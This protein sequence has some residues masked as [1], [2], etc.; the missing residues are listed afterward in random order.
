MIYN[1][2][3]KLKNINDKNILGWNEAIRFIEKI[4]KNPKIEDG[5]YLI[6]EENVYANIESYQTRHME[7]TRYE[8]HQ[9]YIDIQYMIDGQEEIAVTDVAE[10]S[11]DMP[12]DSRRDVTF[13]K[14]FFGGKK[15]LLKDGDFLVLFPEDAHRPCIAVNDECTQVKKMVI[16]VRYK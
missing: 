16:K 7:Q 14:D 10:L 6:A 2:F 3:N 13:Y 1:D 15:Y 11:I 9:D 8:S 12:Y 4:Q 5:K